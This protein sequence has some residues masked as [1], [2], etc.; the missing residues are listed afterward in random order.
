MMSG[1]EERMVNVVDSRVA[2]GAWA[3]GRSSAFTIDGV[4]QPIL[5]VEILGRKTLDN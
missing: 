5:G 2:L 3:K 4:A 1:V